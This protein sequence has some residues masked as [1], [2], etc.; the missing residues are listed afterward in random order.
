MQIFRRVQLI[1][2]AVEGKNLDRGSFST[3][4]AVKIL[5]GHPP[6]LK[7]YECK[8]SDLAVFIMGCGG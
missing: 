4:R 1:V 6:V 3:G 5:S 7:L 8:F 2:L